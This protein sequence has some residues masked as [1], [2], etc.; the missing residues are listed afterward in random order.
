MAAIRL[1][2]MWENFPE[3]FAQTSGEDRVLLAEVFDLFSGEMRKSP[4]L[5]IDTI[6]DRFI[7]S[8]HF[9]EVFTGYTFKERVDLTESLSK[10]SDDRRA[11]EKR[12]LDL[13][14]GWIALNAKPAEPNQSAT[15]KAYRELE[16]ERDAAVAKRDKFAKRIP[17]N[18]AKRD[19][20]MES[21]LRMLMSAVTTI[22][23]RMNR[24]L[25]DVNS[26][27][28]L[29]RGLGVEAS[30]AMTTAVKGHHL[31]MDGY[32]IGAG[33]VS[34]YGFGGTEKYSEI[35]SGMKSLGF[36]VTSTDKPERTGF[37]LRAAIYFGPFH[38]ESKFTKP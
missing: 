9:S 12:L 35:L 38:D 27:T 21:E 28:K 14:N 32:R 31:H 17:A 24:L 25:Y 13:Y 33:Y 20:R 2:N 3:I 8:Y 1:S 37:G 29:V 5:C 36:N 7:S 6:V 19:R 16:A 34:L 10:S 30:K 11:V 15:E 22:E 4:T 26:V 23:N 18:R